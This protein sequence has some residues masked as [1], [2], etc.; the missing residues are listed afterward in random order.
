[1]KNTWFFV[2]G[3]INILFC[4][5]LVLADVDLYQD[6]YQ[7]NNVKIS[8]LLSSDTKAVNNWHLE[9]IWT[10]GGEEEDDVPLGFVKS[11]VYQGD[12]IYVLDTKESKVYV[13]NMLGDCLDVIDVSGDAPGQ[14]SNPNALLPLS[15]NLFALVQGQPA[16]LI[17]TDFY[18]FYPYS[19]Q[20]LVSEATS[21]NY[22]VVNGV[23]YDA[24]KFLAYTETSV[25]LDRD[26]M[27]TTT[28]KALSTFSGDGKEIKRYFF[29]EDKEKY[30]QL[31][32]ERTTAHYAYREH[33]TI[34]SQGRVYVAPY[35]D[36][37]FIYI[38]SPQ[39]SLEN[40]IGRNFVLRQRTPEEM[41]LASFMGEYQGQKFEISVESEE[42]AILAIYIFGD[43]LLVR[44]SY[45]EYRQASGVYSQLDLFVDNKLKEKVNLYA[46]GNARRDDLFFLTED[47]LAVVK[48][49]KD[50][51][52]RG[53]EKYI[54]G[55]QAEP[56]RVILYRIKRD[57]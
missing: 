19:K 4:P 8:P 29:K 22:V 21:Q 32:T 34:D 36:K 56:V 44:H 45:S 46:P 3:L 7:G 48:G 35:R 38:F 26:K 14:C 17:V 37:Y 50:F 23:Y 16:K 53:I 15:N 5:Y 33:F 25:L 40:V 10:L 55:Y 39:G 9:E 28:I 51:E 41:F 54:K 30:R 13:I 12:K 31:P 11:V 24:N 49:N 52:Q 27:D 6:L 2:F 42:A 47:L 57:R 1:M 18:K 20:F 43:D